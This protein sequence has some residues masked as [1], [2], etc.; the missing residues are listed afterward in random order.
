MAKKKNS[1]NTTE[2]FEKAM[3][4]GREHRY[5]LRLYVT[6][7]TPK[8]AR[9]I[10]NLRKICEEHLKGKY[11]LEVIDIYQQPELAQD[12]DIIVTPTLVKKLPLP[13]RK[14]IGDL[15]DT[16]QVIKGMNIVRKG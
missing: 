9:A 3:Q 2:A 6:G 12:A 5:V 1:D 16:D 11:E 8:S 4:N 10:R 14:F 13:L 15:S 7:S